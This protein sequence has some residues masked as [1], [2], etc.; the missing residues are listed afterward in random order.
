MLFNSTEFIFFFL[1][2]VVIIYYLTRC[3]GFFFAGKIW[4]IC[5]SLFFYSWWQYEYLIIL[6]LSV[7]GNY[8]ASK[9]IGRYRSRPVLFC[10]L[11]LNLLPLF[12]YKYTHFVFENIDA[13]FG[14]SFNIERILL[15]L[16]ISFFTFQQIAY[17]VDVYRSKRSFSYTFTD[18]F[19]FVTFFPQLIAGP[20]V[21]HYQLIPQLNNITSKVPHEHFFSGVLL[22][23][24]GLFKKVVIADNLA[25]YANLAFGVHSGN[26]SF[27]DAWVGTLSYSLQLYFDFSGYADMALGVAMMFNIILPINFN[28]PYKSV[29]IKDF[30]SRWHI[31]LSHW[32]RDYIYL[33]LG[34]NRYKTA[35]NVLTTFL[36]GGIWHGAGWGFIIW[37]A[38][39][40]LSLVAYNRWSK[41]GFY[42]PRVI[43]WLI[44][45]MVVHI[46]WVFFRAE[47]LQSSLDI[48][49]SML[50]INTNQHELFAY[51]S[52]IVSKKSI[53]LV[54][55]FFI[56]SVFFQNSNQIIEGYKNNGT[57]AN[58]VKTFVFGLMFG[59]STVLLLS[60][61]HYEFL[62]FN[63]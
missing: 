7:T 29:S 58:K 30:W 24:I 63:F 5:A 37:G 15:P 34:G 46:G 49:E 61:D 18:Y 56:V 1:P 27:V 14:Q 38:I 60:S 32:L 2:F 22:F 28:S 55:T 8:F 45:L 13:F 19:L 33:P 48:V 54:I 40:G 12:Y 52:E 47:S 26:L 23:S 16:A 36:I 4:L 31:T 11:V 42:M 44:T 39:H 3:S 35:R 57:M 41:F 21:H 17:L 50:F 59:V 25:P 6:L 53:F 9:V 43:S 62:Y 20:I 10:T 51:N